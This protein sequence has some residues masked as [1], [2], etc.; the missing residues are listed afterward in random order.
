VAACPDRRLAMGLRA[1]I[2]TGRI[3]VGWT[4]GQGFDD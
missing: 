1:G 2:G 4:R 3:G